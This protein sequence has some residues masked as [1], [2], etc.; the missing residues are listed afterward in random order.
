MEGVM[1]RNLGELRGWDASHV[2]ALLN[3]LGGSAV[4][5]NIAAGSK[6]VTVEDVIKGFFD[7]HGRAIP[8][9]GMT[10][11]VDA[12]R[13]YNFEQPELDY[14]TIHARYQ[15][16]YGDDVNLVSV[17]EF[18]NNCRAVIERV[19]GDKQTTNLLNGP[20]FSFI[21]PCLMGDLGQC[22]DEILIPALDRAYMAEFPRRVFINHRHGTLVEE[23][24]VVEGTRQ[25]RLVQA[26]AE[27]SVCGVY[28][29]G[30]FQGFGI[31]AGRQF[32][33]SLPEEFILSGVEVVAAVA[34]YPAI[35]GRDS[36]IPALDLAALQW[37]SVGRSLFFD[38]SD[39]KADVDHRSLI[40]GGSFSGGLSLL[41]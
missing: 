19:R 22:L 2:L 37:Q 31:E 36:G 24:T 1:D 8:L 29:P 11:I 9:P 21:L 30:V 39:S 28:F 33:T 5:A 40:A 14:A 27:G 38:A 26:M 6:K 10:G 7:R 12:D 17:Q 32:M 35:F 41:G 16:V 3:A 25:D 15:A 23:V 13:K 20:H 4:A 18:T 34:G